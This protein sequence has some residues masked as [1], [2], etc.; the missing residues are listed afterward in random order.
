MLSYEF[1]SFGF[2]ATAMSEL[3]GTAKL[4]STYVLQ[5]YKRHL[6]IELMVNINLRR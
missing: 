6:K 2:D 5:P 3:R 4:Q 1:D